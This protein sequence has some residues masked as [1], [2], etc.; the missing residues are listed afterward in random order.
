M[1]TLPEQEVVMPKHCV[2]AWFTAHKR[3]CR[4][5]NELPL[6]CT[7]YERLYPIALHYVVPDAIAAK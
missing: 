1:I 6:F 7:G 5:Y 3:Y 2:A 4:N